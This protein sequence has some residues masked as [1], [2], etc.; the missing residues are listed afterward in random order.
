MGQLSRRL[1]QA[2]KWIEI[3]RNEGRLLNDLDE[4]CNIDDE[5]KS[6]NEAGILGTLGDDDNVPPLRRD[7]FDEAIE[8][9]PGV[10]A[11]GRP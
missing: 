3:E 4:P 7:S 10:Q 9:L 11:S 1:R 5:V 8:E 2:K 6:R